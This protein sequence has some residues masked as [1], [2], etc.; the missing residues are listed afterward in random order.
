[1]TSKACAWSA[2]ASPRVGSP[3]GTT[4]AGCARVRCAAQGSLDTVKRRMH[5]PDG[6]QGHAGMRQRPDVVCGIVKVSARLAFMGQPGGNNRERTTLLR[7]MGVASACGLDI[8]GSI[9]I[10]V[11]A[12]LFADSRLHSAPWG[13]L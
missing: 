2:P 13:L 4:R 12:G 8:V 5:K 6:W 3:A 10:G 11:L 1:M 7:A 9:L